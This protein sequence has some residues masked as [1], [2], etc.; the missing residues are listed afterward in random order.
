MGESLTITEVEAIT[1]ESFRANTAV[2]SFSIRAFGVFGASMFLLALVDVY[3]E[4]IKLLS[5]DFCF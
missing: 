3:G 2:A 4:T 5:I 1:R